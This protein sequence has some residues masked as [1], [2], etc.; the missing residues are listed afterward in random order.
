M[1]LTVTFLGGNT[2]GHPYDI[3][4]IL[5]LNYSV[6]NTVVFDCFTQSLHL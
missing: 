1:I 5:I 3:V 4:T 2:N 6:K